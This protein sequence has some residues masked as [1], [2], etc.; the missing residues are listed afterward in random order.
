M[1]GFRG[2]DVLRGLGGPDI[3]DPGGGRDRVFGGNGADEVS[4]RD[5]RRD[6]L[7]CG[8]KSDRGTADLRD[9]LRGCERVKR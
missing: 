2:N 5:G 6:L 8:P 1:L 9:R 7:H 4:A 3:L